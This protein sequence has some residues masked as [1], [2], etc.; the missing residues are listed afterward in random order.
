MMND[1][2]LCFNMFIN[3]LSIYP[4]ICGD[5]VQFGVHMFSKKNDDGL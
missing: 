4:D 3:C 1:A 5:S 2:L